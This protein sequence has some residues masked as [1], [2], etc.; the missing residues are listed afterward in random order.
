MS[1]EQWGMGNDK[2]WNMKARSMIVLILFALVFAACPSAGGPAETPL[3]IEMVQI[4]G[5]TFMIGS[6]TSEPGRNSD[7]TQHQVTLS[8]F[9]IGKYQVTQGQYQ[10]VMGTNPSSYRTPPDGENP[11]RRPV[12]RVSWYDAVEFCNRLSEMEGLAPYYAI[13]KTTSDPNN[14]NS[15]DTHKWLVM[16]NAGSNGYRLPTEA[17]WEYACRAG[18]TTAY[19]TGASISDDTGWYRDNSGSRTHEVGKKPANAWG[20]H[21]MH[22]NVWEWCWDWYNSSGS[23]YSSAAAAGPDPAGPVS[24]PCRVYRGGSWYYDGQHLRSAFRYFVN[25]SFRSNSIGFRLV[26]PELGE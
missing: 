5:G 13:G 25:P 2:E 22:G 14:T 16:P 15:D 11:A 9:S 18:T 17:E 7:E 1:K 3:V 19:N 8:S 26:R 21:D 6:P 24:G 20:L 4:S 12:E 10:A 23:Y